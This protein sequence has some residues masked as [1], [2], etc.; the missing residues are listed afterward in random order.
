MFTSASEGGEQYNEIDASPSAAERVRDLGLSAFQGGGLVIPVLP[1]SFAKPIG[2]SLP[3]RK[4]AQFCIAAHQHGLPLSDGPFT[5]IADSLRDQFRGLYAAKAGRLQGE[6]L[7]LELN[8][9]AGDESVVVYGQP[10]QNLPLIIIQDVVLELNAHEAN[11]GWWIVDLISKGHAKGLGTY[12]PSRCEFIAMNYQFYGAESDADF[13]LQVTENENN[14]EAEEVLDITALVQEMRDNYAMYPSKM[15]AELGLDQRPAGKPLSLQRCEK[16]AQELL[17]KQTLS[18][19]STR[20]LTAA[21]ELSKLYR[22]A[23][24][25]NFDYPQSDTDCDAIGG[26]A[27]VLWKHSDQVTEVV[28]H[29]EQMAYEGECIEEIFS[30]KADLNAPST[31]PHFFKAMN[32]YMDMYVAFTNLLLPME[33]SDEEEQ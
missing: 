5:S 4:H 21:I 26:L 23:N 8:I 28:M 14:E 20:V 25:M 17:L 33:C 7:P 31:W 30:L 32:T 27:F 18:D 10:E 16:A 29:Y 22:R 24:R 6:A 13:A 2:S 3:D 15:N 19:K 12:D 11:L 9:V 1:K